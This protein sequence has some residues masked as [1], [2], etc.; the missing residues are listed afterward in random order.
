MLS[1]IFPLEREAYKRGSVITINNH[2]RGASRLIYSK[3][4]KQKS[5]YLSIYQPNLIQPAHF[6]DWQTSHW[7]VYSCWSYHLSASGV[8]CILYS[9][10]SGSSWLT[11]MLA[12]TYKMKILKLVHANH[13]YYASYLSN[14]TGSRFMQIVVSCK[15]RKRPSCSMYMLECTA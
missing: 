5:R 2:W 9:T 1:N 7:H 14:Y 8:L 10:G 12:I 4:L 3:I 11:G 13:D 6:T 15:N